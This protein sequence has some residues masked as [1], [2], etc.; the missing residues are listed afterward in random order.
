[1]NTIEKVMLSS[2]FFKTQKWNTE[3]LRVTQR[4]IGRMRIQT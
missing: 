2:P 4:L 3:V 1:M